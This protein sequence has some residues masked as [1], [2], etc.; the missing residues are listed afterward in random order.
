MIPPALATLQEPRRL[1]RL[2]ESRSTTFTHSVT[3]NWAAKASVGIYYCFLIDTLLQEQ[4]ILDDL[5][6]I[7]KEAGFSAPS[8]R[9]GNKATAALIAS[10]AGERPTTQTGHANNVSVEKGV[11]HYNWDIIS[12]GDRIR[13]Q[14]SP[15]TNPINASV[16]SVTTSELTIAASSGRT[17]K[18]P[19]AD[20]KGGKAVILISG[21]EHEE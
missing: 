4:D 13:I 9:S 6:V 2:V 8:R 16:Q 10:G 3:G 15:N 12:S 14:L 11:L 5:G 18:V 19:I 7:A 21:H 20:L 1:R 17:V